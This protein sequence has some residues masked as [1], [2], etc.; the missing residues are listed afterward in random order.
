MHLP[1]LVNHCCV[2]YFPE[3]QNGLLNPRKIGKFRNFFT[4]R[5]DDRN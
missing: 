2:C 3:N 1:N 4:K 5:V